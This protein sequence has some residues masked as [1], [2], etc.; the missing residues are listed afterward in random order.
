VEG[1]LPKMAGADLDAAA[2][3]ERNEREAARRTIDLSFVSAF[4][5]V[6]LGAA[7]LALLAAVSGAAITG[8]AD[9]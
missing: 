2:P 7:A 5:V 4:R 8:R 6:M 3:L 9:S 1:E